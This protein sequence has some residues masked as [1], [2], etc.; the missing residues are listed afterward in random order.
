[1]PTADE[2]F[3]R[4][5]ASV[6]AARRSVR[7]EFYIFRSG[8]PG[9]LFRD[10]LAAAAARGVKVRALL[11]GL[12]SGELP[13]GYWDGLRAAGG[14]AELFNP[15]SLRRFFIRNHRKLLLVDDEI[16]FVGGFNIAPEYVGDGEARGW[17]DLGL[18]LRGAAVPDLAAA[19]DA[20]WAARGLRSLRHLRLRGLRWRRRWRVPAA[21]QVL[22][23]GPG[24]G[25]NAFQ[26]LLVRGV[27]R[28]RD[29]RIV[30]AYFAPSRPLRR[31]LRHAARGGARVRLILP[32]RSDVP[33]VRAAGRTYYA[34]LL[35]AGVQIA[36]Y[37][38]QVLHAKL[39][40]VDQAV[41][42]GSSNLDA[43]SL[44]LNYEL[45]VRRVD[46]RLAAEGRALFDADWAR[47]TPIPRIGWMRGW[48][49]RLV[50]L[51]ARFFLTR[52]DPWLS[53]RQ[54]RDL[55]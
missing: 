34:S 29:V 32:G 20:L 48:R 46:A 37:R 52:L 44:A 42:V 49:E 15:V 14:E 55:V 26:H 47:S 50:G 8:P 17:R 54:I 3:R 18:E 9:D 16:A 23:T 38:P 27:R 45:M 7:L 13:A 2:A 5:L 12:G 40:I 31:A 21:L 33:L 11:D 24:L 39:A 28:A 1:M 6:A 10:A 51:F 36:E 4:M 22:A 19:F 41:F 25:R 43:R 53:R 35:R 30:A